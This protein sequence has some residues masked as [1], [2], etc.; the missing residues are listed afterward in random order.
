LKLITFPL[1]YVRTRAL[2][3][4]RMFAE[5]GIP[6]LLILLFVGWLMGLSF[7]E[8]L[9]QTQHWAWALLIVSLALTR[10]FAR[11]DTLFLKHLTIYKP[12]LYI[13]EYLVLISPLLLVMAFYQKIST[14][15]LGVLL[16]IAV[17]FLPIPKASEKVR[18]FNFSWIPLSLFEWRT[19]FRKQGIMILFIYF[20]TLMMAKYEAG[21]IIFT[22]F[23]SMIIPSIFNECEPKEWLPRSFS[24]SEKVVIQISVWTLILLPQMLLFFLFHAELWYLALVTW[25]FGA[26]VTA[27]CVVYKYSL[28]SPFRKDVAIGKSAS[29]FIGM[30]MIIFTSP[31]CIFAI[32]YYWRKAKRNLNLMYN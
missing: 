7:L 21:I 19:G 2:Q 18:Y 26:M 31:A 3:V 10:H 6:Y 14:L 17:A 4:Y 29:I 15:F 23:M 8:K 5:A 27:F 13:A 20:A 9:K 16:T 30:M 12:I 22:L 24:L 32:I 11:K 1:F 25:Y 28:W